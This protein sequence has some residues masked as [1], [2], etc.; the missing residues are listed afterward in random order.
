MNLVRRI[1][2]LNPRLVARYSSSAS[3]NI[4]YLP[5]EKNTYNYRFGYF[6]K[7][8]PAGKSFYNLFI[9]EDYNLDNYR[10]LRYYRS[11]ATPEEGI[12]EAIAYIS[13]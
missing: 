5:Y 4:K 11:T 1:V 3:D 10:T 8:L 7:M 2:S 13:G 6:S 12:G 9:C